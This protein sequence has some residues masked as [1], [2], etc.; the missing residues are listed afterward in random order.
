MFFRAIATEGEGA[1][2]IVGGA[3]RRAFEGLKGLV[4]NQ[5]SSILFRSQDGQ[6]IHFGGD[7]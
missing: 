4:G 1:V 3:R 7:A 5:L 6:T 2:Q